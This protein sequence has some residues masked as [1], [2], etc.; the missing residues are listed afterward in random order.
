AHD[1]SD[2]ALE[3]AHLLLIDVV[4][5][6]KL[7]VEEQI[8]VMQ[9]LNAI[10]RETECFKGAREAERLIRLPTGDGMVLLYFDSPEQPVRCALQITEALRKQSQVPVRMGIHSGPV[11]RVMDVNEQT[12]VAGA[13][14]NVGQRIMDCG[15]AGHILLS[16]HIAEDLIQYR[17][18]QPYLHELGECT[19]KHGLKL[20][21]FNFYRDGVGN[22]SLPEKLRH[23]G[24]WRRANAADIVR[25]IRRQASP[26]IVAAAALMLAGLIAALGFF[27]FT[28]QGFLTKK[29]TSP[30]AIPE[31]SIAVL[32]FENRSEN[33]ANEYFAAGIQDEILTRLS[34]IAGL[35]VIS[36]TS[37]QQYKSAPQNLPE[38]ARALGVAHILEGSVQKIGEAARVNVQLIKAEN[39][40]HLWAET[41]D[42]KLTDIFS[43]ESEVAKTIADQ[44]QVRLTG[45]EKEVLAAIPTT[46]AA[47]Y[48]AYLRGLAYTLKAATTPETTLG[49]QKYLREA[50]RLD[51]KFALAWAL[52]S[53]VDAISL[54]T[55][56][57]QPTAELVEETRHA[58]ETAFSLAP[59]L[60]EA[61]LA[62][63]YYEFAC[64]KEYDKALEYFEEA[65]KFLPNKSWIPQAFVTRRQGHWEQSD[66]Y[67]QEAERLDPRNVSLLT[68]HALSF[69]HRRRFD[70][71][72][73]MLEQ[74]LNIA[75][76]DI[77][78]IALQAAI[79]QGRG[80][81]TGASALLAPLRPTA[82][83]ASILEVQ[84]YQ[85]ILERRPGPMIARF[86]EIVSQPDPALG[87]IN[88]ELRFWLGWLQ[89]V[90]GDRVSAEESWRAAR[91]ELK[92]FLAQQPQSLFLLDDLALTSLGLAER[93]DAFDFARHAAQAVPLESDA[94]SGPLPVE[95]L[96]RVAAGL[97]EPDQAIASLQIVLSQ[98]GDSALGLSVPLTPALL[99]L[100]PMF[101]KIRND[102]RFQKLAFPE[103]GE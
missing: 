57:L 82:E 67:F 59:N 46:N 9:K 36:R 68:Q 97:G 18:W 87:Y 38:V 99:Q 43:V 54:Y 72:N 102:P 51:P 39:D 35:T 5:Y 74:V 89:E 41:F 11:S 73:R 1:N 16:Q 12:N 23:R 61:W 70:E 48:D 56:S 95:I 2:L 78:T 77:D 90:G 101:D 27:I 17:Q 62:K 65:R 34:K 69:V 94:V 10:V 84:A 76:D 96:A 14:I 98:P 50:V 26:L 31:K 32:P 75:P 60:G 49:A 80:D 44:L 100:D 19:V 52:L 8:A 58:A 20:H 86:Q 28:H 15:D 79:A 55:L 37:T 30:K 92:T 7:P 6:S 45:R 13:G 47:A 71:A 91:D 88:G 66:K 85:S 53:Q 63:G 24:R 64:L 22:A 21:L 103:K 33:E 42:R 25:P 40:S 29:A 81:L 83:H 93:A 3:I 4:G